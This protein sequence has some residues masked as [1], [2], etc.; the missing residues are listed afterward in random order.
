MKL[1]SS[2]S[3]LLLTFVTLCSC[4]SNF[5]GIEICSLYIDY[6]TLEGNYSQKRVS[7]PHIFP[8][9]RTFVSGTYNKTTN[10]MW[11]FGGATFYDEGEG[12]R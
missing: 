5:T 4:Y 8:S 1:Q 11:I 3:L 10:E 12:M 9:G 7:S 2:F 6:P